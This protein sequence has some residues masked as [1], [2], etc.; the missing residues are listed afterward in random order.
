[1]APEWETV[2]ITEGEVHRDDDEIRIHR[3]PQTLR[4]G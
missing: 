3:T 4:E 1:M 2:E